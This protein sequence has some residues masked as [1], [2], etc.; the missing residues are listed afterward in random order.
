[1]LSCAA[2]GNPAPLVQWKKPGLSFSYVQA[3]MEIIAVKLNR[4]VMMRDKL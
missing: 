4:N 2:Q 1:M 3:F